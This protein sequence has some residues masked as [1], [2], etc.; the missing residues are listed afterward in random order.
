MDEWMLQEPINFL[1]MFLCGSCTVA[2][3]AVIVKAETDVLLT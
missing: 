3:A 2:V 1:Q